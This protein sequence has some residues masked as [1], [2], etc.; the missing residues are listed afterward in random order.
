MTAKRKEPAAAPTPAEIM[1][2]IDGKRAELNGCH[3][4]GEAYSSAA[5]LGTL[6]AEYTTASTNI[7]V[8]QQQRQQSMVIGKRQAEFAGADCRHLIRQSTSCGTVRNKASL[9]RDVTQTQ[10]VTSG[11][12]TLC[13]LAS[14]RA[15]PE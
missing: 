10:G 15:Q 4:E 11:C 9:A 8:A 3:L 2:A 7:Q 12:L 14:Q 5:S 1:A 6:D 13:F